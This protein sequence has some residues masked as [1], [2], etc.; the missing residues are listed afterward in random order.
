[1]Q[2]LL[3]GLFVDRDARAKRVREIGG[4]GE[5]L[6][7]AHSSALIAFP[8]CF[9]SY[10]KSNTSFS[11]CIRLRRPERSRRISSVNRLVRPGGQ[12]PP[13]TRFSGRSQAATG[14]RVKTLAS[15]LAAFRSPLRN[16]S[17]TSSSFCASSRGEWG[18]W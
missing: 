18:R 4:A 13:A 5:I 10:L 6:T 2:V 17:R 9:F 15:R 7:F 16:A 11:S 8:G 1:M 14:V 3:F 12:K